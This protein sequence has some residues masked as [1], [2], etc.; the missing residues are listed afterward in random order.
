L[1]SC[2]LPASILR[3]IAGIGSLKE[4]TFG[5][6][7]GLTGESI[8]V[9]ATMPLESL[10]FYSLKKFDTASLESF[11]G[12]R[13]SQTLEV[14]SVFNTDQR[15]SID[16][17]QVAKALACCRNLKTLFFKLGVRRCVFGRNGLVG[18]QAMVRGCPLL[19]EVA[20]SLTVPAL[21]YVATHFTHLKKCRVINGRAA[22]LSTPYGF[23]PLNEL[24][25]RYPSVK[26]EYG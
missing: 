19:A 11:V 1:H 25:V 6:C 21:H 16:D 17:V 8:A 3:S 26:W 23:P 9:L 7:G 18:L 13:I 2:N 4:L 14:F 10:S 22:R 12:S 20:I 15:T 24:Q 5:T